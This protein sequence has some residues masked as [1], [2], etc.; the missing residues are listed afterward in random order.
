[1]KIKTVLPFLEHQENPERWAVYYGDKAEPEV[2]VPYDI[3]V[4]DSEKHPLLRPLKARGKT[5]LGYLSLAEAETYRYWFEELRAAGVLM[6]E[7]PAWPGHFAIDLRRPEWAEMII[8]KMIP[9]ILQSGFNGVMLDTIDTALELEEKDPKKYA[10]MKV[11]A[12]KLVKAIRTHYPQLK[13]MVNRGFSILPEIEQEIDMVLAESIFISYDFKT[14]K[15]GRFPKEVYEEYSGLLKAAQKR[16]PHLQVFTLDYWPAKDTQRVKMIYEAQ[17]KQ[18]FIPYV[19]TVD[20]QTETREPGTPEPVIT[21]VDD[22]PPA[23]GP[24]GP[25]S[26]AKQP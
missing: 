20:L 18:G 10:G 16:A 14:G 21:P 11:A 7:N 25:A 13:I 15:H 26:R 5:L 23:H 24:G 9:L 12:V 19:S 22:V 17:R 2:F 4:F 1:M 6:E 3:I 8:E